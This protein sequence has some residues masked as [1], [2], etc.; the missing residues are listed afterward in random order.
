MGRTLEGSNSNRKL[1]CLHEHLYAQT[2]EP[3]ACLLYWPQVFPKCHQDPFDKEEI[4]NEN[5]DVDPY[6]KDIPMIIQPSHGK[7]TN[8]LIHTKSKQKQKKISNKKNKNKTT[9]TSKEI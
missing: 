3:V 5:V 8:A 2:N 6:D 4:D 9:F 7:N 1:P